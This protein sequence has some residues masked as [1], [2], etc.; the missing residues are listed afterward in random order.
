[1]VA[2]MSAG[3]VVSGLSFVALA[4]GFFLRES[5][6]D[7]LSPLWMVAALVI[8]TVGELLVAPTGLSAT[9]LLAPEIH[10]SKVMG[11]WFISD[12]LGQAVNTVTVRF[13]DARHPEEF[14][15]L[16]ATVAIAIGAATLLASK[17][18]LRLAG[19]VR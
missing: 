12:A 5:A 8:M 14:F 16:Y 7:P 18:L 3:L 13:F 2:K 19:G 11:L 17:K 15:L 9:T 10:M 6:D 1:M 4:G